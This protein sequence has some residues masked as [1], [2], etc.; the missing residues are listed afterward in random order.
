MTQWKCLDMRNRSIAGR[1]KRWSRAQARSG[2]NFQRYC[3]REIFLG[4][5]YEFNDFI[6]AVHRCYRF[7]Q[8]EP[9]VIDIIYMENER[10]IKEA[11]LEKWKNHNHMVAK[12]IEIV[13]KYGLN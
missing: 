8:K 9:V 6:Q 1:W 3:H 13:K 11:L 10:Q 12:M 7:L 2:C 4:I 5:D